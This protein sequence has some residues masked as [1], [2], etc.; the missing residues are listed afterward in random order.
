MIM[1]APYKVY[2]WKDGPHINA[3]PQVVG[4]YLETLAR[5]QE[6]D[7]VPQLDPV[8]VLDAALVPESPLYAHI[9]RDDVLAAGK[10]RLEEVR[11]IINSIRVVVIDRVREEERKVHA[12]LNVTIAPLNKTPYNRYVPTSTVGKSPS[13]RA[14]VIMKARDGMAAWSKRLLELEGV[15]Q[16]ADLIERIRNLLEAALD[17]DPPTLSA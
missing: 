1:A 8:K 7:G 15:E 9:T 16:I 10:Y 11:R 5:E 2:A 3:D 12:Y 14:D 6:A 13:M 17:A 4:E